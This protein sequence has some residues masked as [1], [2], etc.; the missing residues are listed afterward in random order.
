MRWTAECDLR[1]AAALRYRTLED[2]K[3]RSHFFGEGR[4][5]HALLDISV[6]QT[7]EEEAIAHLLFTWNI[8][9]LVFKRLQL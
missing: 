2:E 4:S 3:K 1:F 7:S 8:M 6:G 9:K 5:D